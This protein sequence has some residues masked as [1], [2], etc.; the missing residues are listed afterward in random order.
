MKCSVHKLNNL[1]QISSIVPTGKLAI[2]YATSD[3]FIDYAKVCQKNFKDIELIG[4]STHKNLISEG[5]ITDAVLIFLSDIEVATYCL[6]DIGDYP[7]LHINQIK[8]TIQKLPSFSPESTICFSLCTFTSHEEMVMSTLEDL[9]KSHHIDLIGGTAATDQQDLSYVMLN[10]T[11]KTDACILTFITNKSGKIKLYK[12]NIFKPT[13]DWFIATEVD[14]DRRLIKKLDNKPCA[15]VIKQIVGHNDLQ[16]QFL[17]NPF[18]LVLNDDIYIVSGKQVHSDGIEYYSNIYK[19]ATLCR[20]ELDDYHKIS[21]ET[22]SNILRDIPHPSGTLVVN[23]ILRTIQF[24]N[25]HF[26]PTFGQNLSKLGNF[27]GFSSFGEQIHYHHCN[28]T[29]VLAVFE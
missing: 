10:D 18:G 11:I 9:F 14:V 25:E 17:S 13:E 19:N 28:Q 12:E 5:F 27:A 6:E 29:L 16:S 21:Q 15:D 2:L 24:E 20:V 23:C 1:Q 22:V 4:C 26:G 3:V 8:K 7:I